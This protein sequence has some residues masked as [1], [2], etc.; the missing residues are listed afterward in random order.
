MSKLSKN[1]DLVDQVCQISRLCYERR[2]VG[3]AGGNVSARLPKGDRFIVTASGVSLR[4]VAP[5][6]LLVID[7]DE[8]VLENPADLKPSK[9][10]RFHLAVYAA[11]PEANAVVHVHP[12]SA[13]TFAVAQSPIPLT[14]I[15]AQLKLK[16]GP[17]VP[18][19]DPGSAEL[20]A[21]VGDALASCPADTSV[22][23]LARHGVVTFASSLTE[24]FNHAEL[25]E[26]TATIALNAD[27]LQVHPEHPLPRAGAR[28]VDLT[29]P[30]NEQIQ[31]Y[32]GD[33]KYSKS[34][35]VFED[36]GFCV[37]KMELGAHSGTHVD[38]PRHFVT[39]GEDI[40]A[41]PLECFFGEAVAIDTPK[42]PDE[43]ITPD[44]FA[45]ADIREGDI[46]LFRTGWEERASSPRFFEG[47]WPG[48]TVEAIDALAGAKVRAIGG[49]IASADGPTAIGAG[50]A[51]HRRAFAAKLPIFEALVN[52]DQVVGKRFFFIGLPLKMEGCEA[53]PIRALALLR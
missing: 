32:P 41:L 2:L 17:I 6:N 36:S 23:L 9:E 35:F 7:A 52:M 44:D 21:K 24:A 25:A 28:V 1:S 26:D 5:D 46:V 3:A 12:A 43:N 14:T 4:D 49:D 33:P 30:L 53:S 38:A 37:S 11:R 50:G 34:W 18:D 8:K 31:C 22:L 42:G 13:T 47:E 16:Q 40:T 29:A 19:A 39:D 48:F 45:G 27:H 15:S 10:I 20:A 51:A